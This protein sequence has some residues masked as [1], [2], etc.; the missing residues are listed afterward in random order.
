MRHVLGFQGEVEVL[1]G[2][3]LPEHLAKKCVETTDICQVGVASRSPEW[4][5][6]LLWWK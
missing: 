2:G 3:K 4:L 5:W 6:L 1:Q